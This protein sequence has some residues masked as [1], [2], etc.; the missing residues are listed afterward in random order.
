MFLSVHFQKRSAS[1][2][3]LSASLGSRPSQLMQSF[4]HLQSAL[5]TFNTFPLADISESEFQ[6]CL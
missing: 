5:K 1:R 3:L 6:I 4:A 2:R